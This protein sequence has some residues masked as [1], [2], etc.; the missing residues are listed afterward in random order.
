MSQPG[1]YQPQPSNS[2]SPAQYQ[3]QQGFARP[4]RPLKDV[5]VA[6]LMMLFT[7]VGICGIQHFYMGK[8]GRG[9]L[10]LFTFGLL[11]VGV[12]VD[13]FTLPSQVR[14]VNAQIASG[15]R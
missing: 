14:Q 10:W 13:L 5:G 11:G 2:P 9:L 8:V 7:L 1:P 3:Y 4:P 6:Y 12:M 15:V